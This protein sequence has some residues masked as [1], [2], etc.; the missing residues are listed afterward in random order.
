MN[1]I[2]RCGMATKKDNKNRFVNF[3]KHRFLGD[4]F[5]RL[6]CPCKLNPDGV[7]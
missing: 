5:K 7:V 3:C 6:S 1:K 2:C 4:C